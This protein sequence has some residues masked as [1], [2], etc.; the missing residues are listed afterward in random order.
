[1]S[2]QGIRPDAAETTPTDPTWEYRRHQIEEATPL[3]R[4]VM[5]YDV[6]LRACARRDLAKVTQA[7]RV[8]DEALDF[9]QGE[10]AI[11]L[12]RLYQFCADAARKGAYEEAMA[13]LR[14][15]REAWVEV[16]RRFGGQQPTPAPIPS[17]SST[18]A[19]ATR[20]GQYI[21]R[22]V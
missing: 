7:L 14:E 12:S 4:V 3:Q 10:I 1:M 13:V 20:P 2:W 15:L 5:V 21:T 6:A 19:R 16:S 11:Q 9:S 8:L 17:V 22:S 18:A